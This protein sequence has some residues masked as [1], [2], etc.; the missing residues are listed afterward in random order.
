MLDAS[1]TR[2]SRG[3]AQGC[4][5][6][7]VIGPPRSELCRGMV[8]GGRGSRAAFG[9]LQYLYFYGAGALLGRA[10]RVVPP[11]SVP[12][13]C[14]LSLYFTTPAGCRGPGARRWRVVAVPYILWRVGAWLE[15]SRRRVLGDSSR[16]TASSLCGTCAGTWARPVWH[17]DGHGSCVARA[18]CGGGHFV[19][20]RG[21][22]C[23]VSLPDNAGGSLVSRV[24]RVVGIR[25]SYAAPSVLRGAPALALAAIDFLCA[26]LVPPLSGR[27]RRNGTCVVAG[28]DW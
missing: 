21:R 26:A 8:G 1:H 5:V 18:G 2:V 28:L 14:T 11:S 15:L 24:W 27:W 13:A 22:F 25:R 7:P 17:M 16:G 4:D 19:Q 10:G 12:C 23:H 9:R 20:Q 6:G 3:H